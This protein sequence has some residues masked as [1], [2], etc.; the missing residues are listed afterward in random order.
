MDVVVLIVDILG[1]IKHRNTMKIVNTTLRTILCICT[2]IFL[3]ACAEYTFNPSFYEY[4]NRSIISI[5]DLINII[6]YPDTMDSSEQRK[7]SLYFSRKEF[8][9][10]LGSKRNKYEMPVIT[11]PHKA[12]SNI[13]ILTS[14][15]KISEEKMALYLNKH[16]FATTRLE[17]YSNKYITPE[18]SSYLIEKQGYNKSILSYYK[19][20]I[21][22]TL[23]NSNS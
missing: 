15:P 3:Y 18:M 9:L 22:C 20:K 8:Y 4:R 6:T 12:T 7:K 5:S 14:D 19:N 11:T 13:I 21:I 23:Y 17:G 10:S 16:G 1:K 2:I